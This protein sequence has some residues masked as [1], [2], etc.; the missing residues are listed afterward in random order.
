LRKYGKYIQKDRFDAELDNTQ[1]NSLPTYNSDCIPGFNYQTP[2]GEMKTNN[3]DLLEHKYDSSEDK[4]KN[5]DST[6]YKLDVIKK[7]GPVGHGVSSTTIDLVHLQISHYKKTRKLI[8]QLKLKQVGKNTQIITK[9]STKNTKNNSSKKPTKS[10]L[11]TRY[12]HLRTPLVKIFQNREPIDPINQYTHGWDQYLRKKIEWKS[13]KLHNLTKYG[14]LNFDNKFPQ[15]HSLKVRLPPILY[16][17]P[18]ETN[19]NGLLLPII[20][21]ELR[22]AHQEGDNNSQNSTNST[23]STNFDKNPPSFSKSTLISKIHP[24]NLTKPFMDFE[25]LLN[26][27]LSEQHQSSLPYS[28]QPALNYQD[29]STSTPIDLDT[30]IQMTSVLARVEVDLESNVPDVVLLFRI[31]ENVKES[32]QKAVVVYVIFA[33]AISPGVQIVNASTLP[34][35]DAAAVELLNRRMR[36]E[37]EMGRKERR[38]NKNGAKIAH[39]GDDD[40]N[41][42]DSSESEGDYSMSGSDTDIDS[43]LGRNKIKTEEKSTEMDQTRQILSKFGKQKG[44]SK[45]KSNKFAQ[46]DQEFDSFTEDDISDDSFIESETD[47]DEISESD[48]FVRNSS[49]S[50]D[51]ETNF[52]QKLIKKKTNQINNIKKEKNI[53]KIIPIKK[54]LI[55]RSM[56]DSDD[57]SDSS[58]SDSDDSDDKYYPPQPRSRNRPL[59]PPNKLPNIGKKTKSPRKSAKNTVVN[60]P[61]KGK[62]AIKEEISDNDGESANEDQN[63]EFGKTSTKTPSKTKTTKKIEA[64]SLNQDDEFA[65]ENAE[66]DM[67]ST[68]ER[69]TKFNK[70]KQASKSAINA[71]QM[72]TMMK[73]RGLEVTCNFSNDV[74]TYLSRIDILKRFQ[75]AINQLVMAGIITIR[76]QKTSGFSIIKRFDG[77]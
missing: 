65:L 9:K 37:E 63:D 4:I 51:S 6:Q 13:K 7:Y 33:Q 2:I 28:T 55:K 20:Q 23:N 16:K 30:L 21:H 66:E 1:F 14:I 72:V 77:F 45:K 48:H 31:L 46:L 19:L 43:Y 60:T 57:S 39:M 34:Q 32:I 29:P 62:R 47:Y 53:K 76:D 40:V 56:T 71:D 36:A 69:L 58:D 67:F 8:R 70:S 35:L 38:R 74:K 52:K 68:M 75:I 3:F 64:K 5:F 59:P 17:N 44:K 26:T 18:L 22:H 54:T 61:T 73:G 41:N 42:E 15:F 50:S 10:D 27:V 11:F 24:S 12:S 25:H 49:T